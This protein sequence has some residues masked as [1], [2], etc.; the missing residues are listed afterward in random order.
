M[1]TFQQHKVA[2]HLYHHYCTRTPSDLLHLQLPPPPHRPVFQKLLNRKERHRDELQVVHLRPQ[3][4]ADIVWQ[5]QLEAT[6][7]E[8]TLAVALPILLC[9]SQL[10]QLQFL[11]PQ[12]HQSPPSSLDSLLIQNF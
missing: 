11:P 1:L 7:Y 5:G 3:R 12:A 8:Q 4:A 10:A 6:R 9:Q 2:S